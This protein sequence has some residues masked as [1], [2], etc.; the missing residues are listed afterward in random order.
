MANQ[1]KRRLNQAGLQQLIKSSGASLVRPG[2]WKNRST[3]VSIALV[4]DQGG[5]IE[6]LI[7][8]NCNC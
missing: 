1:E 5:V 2:F 3:K 4:R 6:V 8:K 7:T